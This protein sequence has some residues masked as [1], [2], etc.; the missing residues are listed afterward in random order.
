[1]PCLV[2]PLTRRA[3]RRPN[4]PVAIN[5]LVSA[6]TLPLVQIV[7]RTRPLAR[8]GAAD[9]ALRRQLHGALGASSRRSSTSPSGA[10]PRIST[11]S[12]SSAPHVRYTHRRAACATIATSATRST[13]TSTSRAAGSRCSSTS[14]PTRTTRRRSRRCCTGSIARRG[15]PTRTRSARSPCTRGFRRVLRRSGY[16]Q[17]K[18]TMEFVDEDQRRGRRRRRSTRTPTAGTSRSATRIRTDDVRCAVACL[19]GIDTEGDNQ[20]DAAARAHQTVR[21]HLRAAAAARA[22]RA[23]RRPADLRDHAIPVATDPRS[24][25]VLRGCS[26]GG[27]CE[28]GAH[29]HAWETP[30]CTAETSRRHPYAS[31]LPRAQFEQQLA[32]LT[33]AIERGRRRA[34]G[35]VSL[36]PVRVL[37]AITCRRSS[38]SATSSNRASRRS[39][40][41]RTRAGRTSSRRRSRRTSWRTTARRGRARS[42]VLEVPVSAALQPPAA[43]AAA[44]RSTRARRGLHDQARASRSSASRACG[45]CG[46]RTRRSTT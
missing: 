5:R 36:R 8:R 3:L 37:R 43:E 6:L 9:P 14:S 16:F 23:A 1:M 10:T 28:I 40:T 11:G 34:A 2:K 13:A 45:G 38:G 24:A 32:S 31:T 30:P 33:E 12:T 17:V 25:D 15:R 35:L 7:A 21:E 39:S 26:A 27:D 41:K 20:W 46:R 18:S 19:V 44:V 42:D 29:H 22:V 4:W